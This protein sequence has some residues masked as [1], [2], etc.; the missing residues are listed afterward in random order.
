MGVKARQRNPA[1]RTS[2]SVTAIR[3]LRRLNQ[4]ET[5]SFDRSPRRS[6]HLEQ[7]LLQIHASTTVPGLDCSFM[8][9]SFGLINEDID[10]ANLPYALPAADG[11][12][13]TDGV[14]RFTSNAGIRE[15]TWASHIVVVRTNAERRRHAHPH[16]SSVHGN[17]GR[18]TVQG[19]TTDFVVLRLARHARQRADHDGDGSKGRHVNTLSLVCNVRR[20]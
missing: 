3:T 18:Q 17:A 9:H 4:W 10:Y 12:I 15:C 20:Q 11:T 8:E 16:R 1:D 14:I 19:S 2:S 13:V 5:L 7:K 6:R